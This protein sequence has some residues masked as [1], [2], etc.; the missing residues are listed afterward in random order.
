MFKAIDKRT[1][2][3]SSVNE[4]MTKYT[5]DDLQTGYTNN[6]VTHVHTVEKTDNFTFLGFSVNNNNLS[7]Y[8][9]TI[10]QN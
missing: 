8:K 9:I 2:K 1:K 6:C 3:W 5:V 10:Y 7:N 4:S